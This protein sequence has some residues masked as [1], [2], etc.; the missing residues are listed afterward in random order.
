VSRAHE[1]RPVGEDGKVVAQRNRW[2]DRSRNLR[3]RSAD[4]EVRVKFGA[5]LDGSG[6]L[7]FDQDT[8]PRDWL[9]SD[10][11]DAQFTLAEWGKS[12]RVIMS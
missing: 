4:G 5:G 2:T 3:L 12:E 11:G 6:L 10:K 9:A 8:E 7:L 1:I